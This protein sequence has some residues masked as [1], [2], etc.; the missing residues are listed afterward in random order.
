MAILKDPTVSHIIVEHR[1]RLTRFG[2][3]L[4]QSTLEASGRKVVVMNDAELSDDLVRDFVEIVTS[5][6]ARIYGKRSGKRKAERA[7][8]ALDES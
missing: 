5:M 2:F 7:L 1:D 8:K 4:I 6:C 3:D